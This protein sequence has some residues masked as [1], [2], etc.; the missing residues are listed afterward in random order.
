M[1]AK[2]LNRRQAW[3][4]LYLAC[5]DFVLHHKPGKT[6]GKPD[7][8]SRQADHGTGAD[9][10]SNIVLLPPKLFAIRALEGL[11]FAGS[12]WDILRDIHQ[13]VRQL[14]EEPVT[15]A[16]QQMRNSSTRSL[17]SVEWSEHDSLLYYRGHIYIPTSSE[18]CRC[19]ISL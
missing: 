5:F 10:N 19:I 15:K 4:S 18:L 2:Q 13:G 7:A 8:L 3:W 1:T 17:Q 9:D 11:E 12:E 6:M 14:E 16:V